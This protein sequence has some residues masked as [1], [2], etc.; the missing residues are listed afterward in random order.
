MSTLILD[1]P[2]TLYDQVSAVS[3]LLLHKV[4]I[5]NPTTAATFF[6]QKLKTLQ[7]HVKNLFCLS[8][9]LKN[10]AEGKSYAG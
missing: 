1:E 6:R 4:I 9:A 5:T 2:V 3:F 10:A 8:H 7:I